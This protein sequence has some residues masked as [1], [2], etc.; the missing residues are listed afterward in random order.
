MLR[1]VPAS[2]PAG[3]NRETESPPRTHGA[4][5]GLFADYSP[6]APLDV[7]RVASTRKSRGEFEISGRSKN[8][9]QE[10]WHGQPPVYG[11]VPA[12]G[13]CQVVCVTWF[14]GAG[15]GESRENLLRLS[16]IHGANSGRR[17]PKTATI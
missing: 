5:R 9:M 3:A 11:V 15:T 14:V 17:R 10:C 16:A 1:A 12:V 4:D 13:R 8:R 6:L 2:I 7:T